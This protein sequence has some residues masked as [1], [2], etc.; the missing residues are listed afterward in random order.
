MHTMWQELIQAVGT[1]SFGLLK[2]TFQM[3][4]DKKK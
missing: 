1:K 4:G 3:G 2:S